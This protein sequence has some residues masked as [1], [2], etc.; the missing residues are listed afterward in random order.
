LVLTVS[1]RPSK[2]PALRNA[3]RLLSTVHELHK[4]GYQRLRVSCGMSPS[5]IY[6]RCLIASADDFDADGFS[7]TYATPQDQIAHY[8][9]SAGDRYF[10]WPDAVGLSARELAA[11]FIERCPAIAAKGAGRDWP[12]AGWYTEML[13][14]AEHGRPGDIPVFFADYPL[15][16]DPERLPPPRP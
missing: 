1:Q 15:A 5:G 7:I 11:R 3:T 4:A 6:W 14:A 8:S 10:D 12:Y 16:L 13:G 9:S 2:E